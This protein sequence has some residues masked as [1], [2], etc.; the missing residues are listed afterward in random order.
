MDARLLRAVCILVFFCSLSAIYAT[1]SQVGGQTHLDY[2]EWYAKLIPAVALAWVFMRATAAALKSE[3]AVNSATLRWLSVSLMLMALMAAMTYYQHINEPPPEEEE[4]DS[5]SL[6]DY[7]GAAP[8]PV[9]FGLQTLTKP[10]VF[11]RTQRRF[12]R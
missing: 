3:R 4:E 9:R 2:M 6:G 7:R 5:F 8:D 10:Q 12:I 1:W 11:P